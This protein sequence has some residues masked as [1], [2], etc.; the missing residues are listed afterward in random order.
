MS[1]VEHNLVYIRF[2]LKTTTKRTK[3]GVGRVAWQLRTRFALPKDP[4]L[5]LSTLLGSLPSP[6]TPAT[7]GSNSSGF[8]GHL[9]L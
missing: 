1:N 5:I 7:G 6:G 3:G 2:C 8:W 4:S 9:Y